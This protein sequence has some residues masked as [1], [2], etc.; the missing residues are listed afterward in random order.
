MNFNNLKKEC[1]VIDIETS[2]HF[3][4]GREINIKSDFETYVLMAQCKWFGAYS[5]KYDKY[6]YLNA[7]KYRT[8]ICDILKDH[9]I[10]VGFNNEDFD[11]EILLNN[12]LLLKDDKHI[13][14]DCMTILGKSN[15]KNKQGFSYK[16]RGELMDYKFKKNSLEHMAQIMQIETQKGNIDYKIFSKDSWSEDEQKEI[17]TYLESDIKANKQIFDKLWDYW[18]PFTDLLDYKNIKNLSWIRSSIASL[19]YKS[20]CYSLNVKPEFNDASNKKIEEMGGRVIEPRVEEKTRVWYIDF[21]SLYPHIMCMFN[22]FAEVDKDTKNA[23]HGNKLFQVKGY[24]NIDSQHKLSEIVQEK[25]KERIKLQKN[26][27][28]S[29]MIYTYKI[30]LNSLYGIVRSSIFKHVHTPNSGWDCCWLGQQI[31][32]F[33]EEK[34]EALGFE[35]IAGDTDSLF[36]YTNRENYNTK[37]YVKECLQQIINEIFDNVPFP[38]KTFNID[39]EKY[40][41]YIMFPFDNQP[42]VHEELRQ[43]LTAS[44]EVNGYIKALDE[45]DKKIIIQEDTGKIIKQ[46]NKWITVRKGKKKNYTYIYTENGEKKVKLVGLPIIKDNATKLGIMI[47]EEILKKEII[48]NNNAKFI[49]ENINNIIS[50]YLKKDNIMKVISIEY[51]VKPFSTY[52]TES[53]QAQI[54]KNYLN[55]EEGV[56]SLVKNNKIGKVGKGSK[57]CTI[58]EAESNNLQIE[59]LDLEKLYNELDPFIKYEVK[60]LN[61]V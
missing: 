4:D 35:I 21:K 17:I 23:W 58:E 9:K 40:I 33:T 43:K 26:D 42:I 11:C 3:N 10:L 25:L 44:I 34:M 55:E 31:H 53:I 45:N 50:E 27:P 29:P 37:E 61:N 39:I 28:K 12:N 6:F 30:F 16:N 46:G 24:Y 14:V 8:Q 7:K 38:I 36:L 47:Y 13:K 51:K 19:T 15:F 54:S 1:L 20:V 52:K 49:K 60:E 22:L 41:D 5:Y 32:K 56:I 2:S 59:D 57:Y 18:K 48:K